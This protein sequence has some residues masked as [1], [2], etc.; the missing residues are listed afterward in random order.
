MTT[1]IVASSTPLD[2]EAPR[3]WIAVLE[4]L[5]RSQSD[6][7]RLLRDN[8]RIGGAIRVLLSVSVAGLT[9]HGLVLAAVATAL[10]VADLFS[11][12]WMPL[13]FVTSFLGAI[14]ICLPSFYFYTQL[15][16]LD[17]SFRLITAQ[18]L[19]AQATTAVFVLG[20]LPFYAALALAAAIGLIVNGE[21][22]IGIGA[23]LPFFV[24]LIGLK[25]VYDGFSRLSSSLERTH[26]RRGAYLRRMVLCW[27]AVYTAVAPIALWRIT[28]TFGLD[29][30]EA[31][32]KAL[33]LIF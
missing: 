6:L 7:D 20:V 27:G 25:A 15:S 17:A 9:L 26:L 31:A 8:D 30:I 28:E 21:A 14:S 23:G 19:R 10:G 24:G 11:F 22:V 18:A 3:G 29:L 4:A 16:G 32:G 1:T 12:A 13:A 33:A 2:P 5:I